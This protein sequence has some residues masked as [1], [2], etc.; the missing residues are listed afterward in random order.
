MSAVEKNVFS[1]I[2][3]YLIAYIAGFVASWDCRACITRVS[4]QFH[5]SLPQIDDEYCR[6]P[7]ID[8]LDKSRFDTFPTNKYGLNPYNRVVFRDTGLA[9]YFCDR[10]KRDSW[11]SLNTLKEIDFITAP[12]KLYEIEFANDA[13]ENFPNLERVGEIYRTPRENV[14]S[15]RSSVSLIPKNDKVNILTVDAFSRIDLENIFQF[16]NVTTLRLTISAPIDDFNIGR[17]SE[18]LRLKRL[19][20]YTMVTPLPDLLTMIENLK[21][22]DLQFEYKKNRSHYCMIKSNTLE[23]IIFHRYKVS[24]G[25]PNV[26]KI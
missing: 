22:T 3:P 15:Y 5:R 11:V 8:R 14:F 26:P 17:L 7:R 21:I 25:C 1:C 4:K 12:S 18:L 19:C 13:F 6:S 20:I 16:E 10:A 24:I 2:P 23:R 9:S